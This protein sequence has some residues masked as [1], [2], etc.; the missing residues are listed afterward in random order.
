MS[1]SEA[2]PPAPAD[3]RTLFFFTTTLTVTL[4]TLLHLLPLPLLS[5]RLFPLHAALYRCGCPRKGL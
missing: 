4:C 2:A 1:S 3:R 5:R